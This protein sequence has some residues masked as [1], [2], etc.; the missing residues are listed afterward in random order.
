[1]RV[2]SYDTISQ[3]TFLGATFFS[4]IIFKIE[5]SISKYV[6]KEIS[7]SVSGIFHQNT[8]DHIILFLTSSSYKIKILI[9]FF[10]N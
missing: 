9:F 2:L 8:S 6:S 4:P 3:N 7:S 5:Q 1:M 10:F